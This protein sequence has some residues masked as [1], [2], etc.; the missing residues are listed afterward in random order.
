MFR[1]TDK[2]KSPTTLQFNQRWSY[3]SAHLAA[4]P[5]TIS[6]VES[7]PDDKIRDIGFLENELIP[8]IGLNDENLH[9]QPTELGKY[10]GTGIHVFQYPNQ[11]ARYLAWLAEHATETHSYVEVGSR[12]G[13]TFILT[14]EWLRRI[15]A[16]L[17]RAVA[18]DPIGETP[19]LEKYGESLLKRNTHYQFIKDFS[20]SQPVKGMFKE[21][22]PDF[23]FIDGDH[24]L[25]G[26]LADHML[27]RTSARIL[28]HHDVSSDACPDT[29]D[30]WQALKE[31][32]AE[33]FVSYDFTDQYSSVKGSYLG[34]GALKRKVNS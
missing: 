34:I 5:A 32:E 13:G 30:L 26:A 9:E 17:T 33:C 4:V 19:M 28:V 27:A 8:L 6:L 20:S 24:S 14:C 1:L 16:P 3:F 25:K 15:G 7:V 12:W 23:V 2:K 21:V 31:L 11:F 18:I 10:F 29:T 22:G